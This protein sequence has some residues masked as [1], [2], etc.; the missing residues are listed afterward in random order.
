[1]RYLP[2]R[3]VRRVKPWFALAVAGLLTAVLLGAAFEV[4]DAE[5][6]IRGPGGVGEMPIEV[7]EAAAAAAMLPLPERMRAVSEALLAQPYLLDPLGEGQGIDG[8]PLARYDAFDCL[9]FL[10]ETLALAL[11][12]DPAGAGRVRKELRYGDGPVSYETRHHFMEMQWIPANEKRGFIRKTTGDYGEK[13]IRLSKTVTLD[14][15]SRWA[16]R[17]LFPLKDADLPMGPMSL[18]VLPLDAALR[19]VDEIRP[20]TLVF[21]VRSDRGGVPIWISHVGFTVPADS[22]TVRHATKMGSDRSRDHSLSWYLEH[23]KTYKNWTALGVS[24]YEPVEQGPRRVVR[25]G[26]VHR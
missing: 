8:D 10:E 17:H 4:G 18:D 19:V 1:M 22:P 12:A 3:P 21:T 15:W 26:T 13:T 11:S 24:L 6:G 20:G 23:L 7:S 5:L 2:A 25:Q 16:R 9:T 14:T